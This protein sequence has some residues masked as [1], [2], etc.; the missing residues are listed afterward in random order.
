MMRFLK[1]AILL[2]VIVF[3]TGCAA[4]WRDKAGNP[5]TKSDEFGCDTKCGY[6]DPNQDYISFS[7]CKDR[8]MTSKGYKAYID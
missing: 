7:Q 4:T 6:Y 2:A 8:C 5:S 1:L 3:L